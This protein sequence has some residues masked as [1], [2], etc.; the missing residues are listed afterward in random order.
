[1]SPQ[2]S[3]HG[4]GSH[5]GPRRSFVV[6]AAGLRP[7]RR[8]ESAA[9]HQIPKLGTRGQS[10]RAIPASQK[11]SGRYIG[12]TS[13]ESQLAVHSNKCAREKH[14][15]PGNGTQRKHVWPEN[16]TQE[17]VWL[18][19]GTQGVLSG[20]CLGWYLA[21]L[22][23]VAPH[24]F[25]PCHVHGR[26]YGSL[27]DDPADGPPTL[28]PRVVSSLH[29]VGNSVVHYIARTWDL[30]GFVWSELDRLECSP[31]ATL[32]ELASKL[33]RHDPLL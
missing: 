17:K 30:A 5:C 21:R 19:G 25:S 15:W 13:L 20:L 7:K 33:R 6:A 8:G 26:A 18:K 14:L 1:M 28:T 24:S 3:A 32:G 9:C 23:A 4:S 11:H 10:S 2:Y 27:P 29:L 31:K 16:G 22:I 12:N